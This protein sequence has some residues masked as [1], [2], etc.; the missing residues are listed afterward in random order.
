MNPVNTGGLIL[1]EGEVLGAI[2]R[3]RQRSKIAPEQGGVLLGYRRDP[4]L[5]VVSAS[6]PARGDHATR[7]SFKREDP[8]HAAKALRMWKN[9]DRKIDYLGEWHT[10]PEMHPNP[11]SIDKHA[12]AAIRA[13]THEVMLFVIAGT[14]EDWWIGCG[15]HNGIAQ[16]DPKLV[17]AP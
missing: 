12:W 3:H 13:V 11:S 14:D 17:T 2:A 1:L 10:H 7:I 15:D 8:S 9:T 6:F 4:H 5:H 16:V